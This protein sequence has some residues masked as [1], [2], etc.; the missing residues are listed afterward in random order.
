MIEEGETKE[1]E[2]EGEE[3]EEES[4]VDAEGKEMDTEVSLN[5]SQF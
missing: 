3:G 5:L 1:D 2:K 4:G